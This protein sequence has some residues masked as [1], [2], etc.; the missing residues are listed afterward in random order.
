MPHQRLTNQRL[1]S[2]DSPP[3][4]PPSPP[5][6]RLAEARVVGGR[7]V[8]APSPKLGPASGADEPPLVV[9]GGPDEA[10]ARVWL[11]CVSARACVCV[12]N[13]A[14]VC[15]RARLA[16]AGAARRETRAA[17]A[18]A[19]VCPLDLRRRLGSTATPPPPAAPI[20]DRLLV[21]TPPV[22]SSRSVGVLVFSPARLGS[23]PNPNHANARKTTTVHRPR[24]QQQRETTPTRRRID[25]HRPPAARAP[26]GPLAAAELGLLRRRRRLCAPD[27]GGRR[28][29]EAAAAQAR[30]GCPP[31][32]VVRKQLKSGLGPS[33]TGATNCERDPSSRILLVWCVSTRGKIGPQS[34]RDARGRVAADPGERRGA[35]NAPRRG[36]TTARTRVSR[37]VARQDRLPSRNVVK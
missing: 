6:A 7:R 28:E 33:R 36:R 10:R 37:S 19:A 29:R 15:A 32:T 4:P 24:D 34:R 16:A 30:G 12:T 20:I 18:T 31:T 13:R 11:C 22:A 3:T 35:P 14:R 23:I 1:L 5:P 21:V 2:L 26:A 8:G 27:G 17:R 25:D 9:L